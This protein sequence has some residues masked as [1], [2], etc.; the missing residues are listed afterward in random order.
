V[1]KV[2]RYIFIAII[3]SSIFYAYYSTT[4]FF[5]FRIL[6]F[7]SVFA[8]YFLIAILFSFK[9]TKKVRNPFSKNLLIFYLTIVSLILIFSIRLNEKDLIT[10]F[11]HPYSFLAFFI[12]IVAFLVNKKSLK[13][14]KLVSTYSLIVIPLVTVVDL[15][16]F[17]FP[18]ILVNCYSLILYSC[19]TSKIKK[20]RLISGA[21]LLCCIPIFAVYDYRSGILIISLLFLGFLMVK[22][23]KFVLNVVV[24]YLFLITSLGLIYFLFFNFTEIFEFLSSQ[25]AIKS[26]NNIDSRTFLFVDFFTDFRVDDF[27]T[28]RGFLGTYFSPYFQEWQGDFGDSF[29]R[30]T[31]E[32]GF[33]QLLLKGGFVLVISTIFIFIRAIYL[34]FIRSKPGS[35]NFT[36]SVWLLIEFTMLSIENVPCFN[37]HFLLIW[38]V[39]GKMYLMKPRFKRLN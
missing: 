6:S 34:G 10:L 12:G 19:I 27:Y 2:T 23:F 13:F 21:L 14:V 3:L 15:L 22:L 30:F 1:Q 8:V 39:I 7:V 18:V 31:I 36:L 29:N 16:L 38:V 28:G 33:L 26:V 25:L 37:I 9:N 5:A 35:V 20:I 11:F 17:N 24:R 32:I 4:L